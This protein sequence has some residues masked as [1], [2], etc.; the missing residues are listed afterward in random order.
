L[1]GLNRPLLATIPDEPDQVVRLALFRDEHP[2]IT[3]GAGV[4]YW[5]G[6]VPEVN[7][8]KLDELLSGKAALAIGVARGTRYIGEASDEQLK[9]IRE[10]VVDLLKHERLL[11]GHVL[12]ELHLVLEEVAA[13]ADRR[14]MFSQDRHGLRDGSSPGVVGSH[15]GQRAEGAE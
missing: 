11:Q 5:Q 4:G 15:P 14:A 8:D 12:T 6:I 9:E 10:G 13:E 7:R 3:V 2:G 1:T